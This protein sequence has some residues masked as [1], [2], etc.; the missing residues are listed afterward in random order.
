M[1]KL[2]IIVRVTTDMYFSQGGWVFKK[3]VKPLKRKSVGGIHDILVDAE[4]GLNI[5]NLMDMR[6]G[7]YELDWC[8]ISR[9]CE[10]GIIDDWAYK[11]VPFKD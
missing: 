2:K 8:N 11:L 7:V 4:D 1:S 3:T 10:T 9:D 6:D 5:T